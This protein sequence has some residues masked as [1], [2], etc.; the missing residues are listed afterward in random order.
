M[1]LILIKEVKSLGKRGEVKEVADGYARNF[2]LPRGLAI[3]ATNRAI[4]NINHPLGE[5]H[6]NIKTNNESLERLRNFVKHS[7]LEIKVKA[8]E[9]GHLFAS[10][11]ASTIARELEKQ[12]GLK[13]KV[14]DI[15]LKEK[16]KV[17]GEYIIFINTGGD[18]IKMRIVVRE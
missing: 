4:K 16:I 15:K 6:K 10:V 3:L 8:N 12:R 18:E 7:T 14:K 1:K 17:L 9:A 2:L 5:K 13:I 11:S